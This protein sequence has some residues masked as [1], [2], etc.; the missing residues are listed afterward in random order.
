MKP[1][2]VFCTQVP[3]FEIELS[4]VHARDTP[5][6]KDSI[7]AMKPKL[8]MTWGATLALGKTC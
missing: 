7:R 1:Y 2:K 5:H 4:S 8:L 3:L 6:L